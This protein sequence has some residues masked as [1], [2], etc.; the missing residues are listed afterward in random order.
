MV[1]VGAGGMRGQW[2]SEPPIA[3]ARPTR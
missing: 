2:Q 3:H 1:Q